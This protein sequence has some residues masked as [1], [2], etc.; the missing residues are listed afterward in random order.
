MAT[1]TDLLTLDDYMTLDWPEDGRKLELVRG[2]VVE[3][4]APGAWHGH[5]RFTLTCLMADFVERHR[6]GLV[7]GENNTYVLDADARTVRIPD[8][9]YIINERI[10]TGWTTMI[11]W[12]FAPDLAVGIVSPNDSKREVSA[13]ADDYLASGVR[14][15]WV[16]WL[17]TQTVTVHTPDIEPRTLTTADTLD[18]GEVLPG[19]AVSVASLFAVN[20]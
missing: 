3:V 7:N 19:F 6:L 10:P 18:G 1:T 13:K 8:V 15:V 16:I 4:A 11:V 14:L 12:P 2:E 9:S 20:L 5:I 17:E